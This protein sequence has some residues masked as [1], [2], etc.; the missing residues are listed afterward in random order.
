M[1]RRE[2]SKIIDRMLELDY[3]SE[4]LNEEL[5]VINDMVL[6]YY[7]DTYVSRYNSFRNDWNSYVNGW[8]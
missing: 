1:S 8:N 6:N 2:L 4:E 3:E 5:E 7:K